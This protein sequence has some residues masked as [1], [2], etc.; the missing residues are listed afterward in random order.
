MLQTSK[1]IIL[2]PT[3]IE[4]IPNFNFWQKLKIFMLPSDAESACV[5]NQKEKIFILLSEAQ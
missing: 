1:K 2:F 3:E 5:Y 4:N